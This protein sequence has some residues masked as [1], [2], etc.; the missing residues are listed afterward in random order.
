MNHIQAV[1][2]FRMN[3]HQ[4]QGRVRPH[5]RPQNRPSAYAH[6]RVQL[7]FDRLVANGPRQIIPAD[8]SY[9]AKLGRSAE[10]LGSAHLEQLKGVGQ[11]AGGAVQTA[12][13]SP[14]GV[15]EA[16]GRTAVAVTGGQA[17]FPQ[18]GPIDK[19]GQGIEK[20]GEGLYRSFKATDDV[21][22][23]GVKTAYY[24]PLAGIEAAAVG[25]GAVAGTAAR[26]GHW[27]SNQV[28]KSFV[29]QAFASGYQSAMPS[30]N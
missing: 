4:V 5:A 1:S 23:A 25:A 7:R 17:H 10:A 28:Q 18:G 27:A 16:V 11:F 26:A 3:P 14:L 22:V 13:W 12:V 30:P 20:M 24:A 19:M 8:Q 2:P 9:A 6:D 15:V 21:L 29:G